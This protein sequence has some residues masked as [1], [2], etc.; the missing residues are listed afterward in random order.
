LLGI[1][2]RKTAAILFLFTLFFNWI[3][4]RVVFSL[5]ENKHNKQMLLKLDENNYDESDLISVKTYYPLP[6]L[7]NSPD[8]ERWNGEINIDGILYKYVKRRFIN[9]SIEFLCLPD[10]KSMQL[11]SAREKF[12][13]LA[14]DLQQNDQNKKSD[15]RVPAFKHLLNEY[16]EEIQGFDFTIIG[17][18]LS[19]H[20]S[21]LTPHTSFYGSI[22]GQPPDLS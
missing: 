10:Y 16:C 21:Y 13:R 22:P 6:Y 12:F 3:G 7:T 9:D 8:F 19:H 4:Y 18:K 20:T 5:A 11:Q 1:T 15:Q 14:N 2:L 17:S